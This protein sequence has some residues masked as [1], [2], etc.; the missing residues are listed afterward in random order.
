MKRFFT[1]L[2]FTLSFFL[3]GCNT[4]AER[5]A[6]NSITNYYKAIIDGEY[7]A[8]FKELYLYDE[9]FLDDQTALSNSD[10]TSYFSEKNRVIKTTK[11]SD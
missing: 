9:S 8:A 5:L 11:L 3:V 6:V 1:F 4:I 10:S 2:L 7:E